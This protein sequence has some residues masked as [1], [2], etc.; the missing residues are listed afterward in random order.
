MKPG[1]ARCCCAWSV[2][3]SFLL[4]AAG[5]LWAAD[6]PLED[7]DGAVLRELEHDL[8]GKWWNNA[9]RQRLRITINDPALLQTRGAAI[10]LNTPDPLLLVNT[11]RLRR[12]LADLRAISLQGD[13]WPCGV[14][15]FGQDDGLSQIW[16]QAPLAK[17]KLPLTFYL[18]FANP[19]VEPAAPPTPP[20]FE[21]REPAVTPDW[22]PLEVAG[23][24]PAPDGATHD[25]F[26]R[27]IVAE[28]EQ[29]T[30][31]D[32]R[33]VTEHVKY[34][35]PHLLPID[36][37]EGAS[38]GHYVAS[39]IPWRPSPIETP[40]RATHTVTIPRPGAWRV[41]VRYRTSIYYPLTHRLRGGD[42]Q[43]KFEPFEFHVGTQVFTAGVRQENG[44]NYRWDTFDVDL[45]AGQVQLE[46]V[47]PRLSGPDVVLLTQDRDYLPD[48]RDFTGPVWLRVQL[49]GQSAPAVA[50][51]FCVHTPWSSHGPQGDTA[52]YLFAQRSTPDQRE[53]L[54]L[55][56]KPEHRLRPGAWSAWGQTVDSKY[57]LWWTT[58]RLYDQMNARPRPLRQATVRFE[59]ATRPDPQRVFRSGAE[60]VDDKGLSILMASSRDFPAIA[61]NVRSFRQWSQERYDQVAQLGLTPTPGPRRI[62]YATMFTAASDDEFAQT[63]ST[64]Q[65][66]GFSTFS[67]HHADGVV[68]RTFAKLGL[69]P[70]TVAHHWYPQVELTKVPAQ[71]PP[72][73][74]AR[75][76]L[77]QIIHD[78]AIAEYTPPARGWP[79]FRRDAQLVVMGDE[80]GP[81]ISSPF[82]NAVPLIQQAF[83]QYLQEQN[84]TPD[85]FGK[86][87]WEQVE[88]LDYQTLGAIARNVMRAINPQ[89]QT[90]DQRQAQERDTQLLRDSLQ[91]DPRDLTDAQEITA[92]TDAA[93]PAA[94][95]P[96][97]NLE[98]DNQTAAEQEEARAAGELLDSTRSAA[99]LTEKRLYHW[100]QRFKGDY[101]HLV[102]SHGKQAIKS[103]YA[104]QYFTNE[105]LA[106]PNFQ[107][108]PF[109]RGHQ[110]N[111]ALN[112][113]ELARRQSLDHLQV[114]DWT[115]NPYAVAFGMRFLQAASR[116]HGQTNGALIVGGGPLQR[117]TVYL[118]FNVRSLFSYL[119]G[120][121]RV[122]GPPWADQ[123]QSVIDYHR[124]GRWMARLEDD[125][126]NSQVRPVRAAVLVANTTEMNR[127]FYS[128]LLRD[129]QC[130]YVAL[131]DSHLPLEAVSEE[132]V[133]L[134]D[135]L[136]RYRLLYVT[137]PHVDSRA[138]TKIAQWVEQ[139][140]LLWGSFPALARQEYDEPSPWATK[141]FGLSDR[142]ELPPAPPDSPEPGTVR[143]DLPATDYWPAQTL[144]A[145]REPNWRVADAQVLAKFPDGA[146]AIIE[147]AYGKGRVFLLSLYARQLAGAYNH[148]TTETPELQPQRQLVTFPCQLAG[149]EPEVE[150]DAPRLMT[151]MRDGR[152]FSLLFVVSTLDV[153]QREV[154]L[155]VRLPFVPT[156]ATDADGQPVAFQMF[157]GAAQPTALVQLDMPFRDSRI[158]RF[159]R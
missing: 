126:Q 132:E 154:A 106:S 142:G 2:V 91:R 63:M 147:H 75:Q 29:F 5:A 112:I 17:R 105:P 22:A 56:T 140:G 155:R 116:P 144:M 72:G 30:A 85:F 10:R 108:F 95:G 111:G 101:T 65:C 57:P 137:D 50:D 93:R 8:G 42:V 58:I 110:W 97:G 118:A 6:D 49:V 66:L 90:D 26:S 151:F 74:T 53:A 114:E 55:F 131:L 104:K 117:G 3:V 157:A 129:R 21:A 150:T 119:Y 41:H 103:A 45:P 13:P 34:E 88:A 123:T 80:I 107:A 121:L 7:L 12:D 14:L 60:P 32:G 145:H 36:N 138:Q 96:T 69:R 73:L 4:G 24:A 20:Q 113:F 133:M 52:C 99:P 46:L 159:A 25:F 125:L 59:L 35:Q 11:G 130:V 153:P 79:G 61:A 128:H 76:A 15:N 82:I 84:L 16:V 1:W 27:F 23:G 87:N 39:T 109:M 9:Y 62:T 86:D 148:T 92:T 120:P 156:A 127:A 67:T 31:P 149:I 18:Y 100:T 136:S 38:G 94:A 135:A 54:K 71:P 134:D 141:L 124:L 47:M 51:V 37:P 78:T 122:I 158:I 77:E 146:P 102:L 89:W 43:I 139:G 115:W 81:F 44:A 48:A 68:E 143:L 152:D 98:L 28:V 19:Q 40:R 70:R 64:L 83:R 33:G